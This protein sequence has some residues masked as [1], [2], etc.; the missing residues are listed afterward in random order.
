MCVS[1]DPINPNLY[2]FPCLVNSKVKPFK[3]AS[4]TY[5]PDGFEYVGGLLPTLTSIISKS[6]HSSSGDNNG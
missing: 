1:L 5:E 6:A 3:Y 4:L 2:G